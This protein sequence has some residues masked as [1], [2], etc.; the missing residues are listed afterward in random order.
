MKLSKIEICVIGLGY[1][2]LSV[3]I[4][5][6]KKYR[7]FGYD[8][9]Q[10]RI[11]ELKKF[12][13]INQEIP[14]KSLRD[15]LNKNLSL[16]ENP[17][18]IENKDIYIV[19]VPT[20]IF[21]NNKPDLSLVESAS[22]LVGKLLKKGSIVIYESTFYPGCT[23]DICIPIIEKHSKLKFNVDFFCGYSPERIN[24][25]DKAHTFNR[26]S[27]IVSGSDVK[28]TNKI[29][30]LYSS[31]VDKVFKSESIKTAEMAKII[32]NSQRDINIAFINEISI[33][34]SK[35]GIKTNE[36]LK[37][38]NTKWNFLD[39][40]PG[41]V[42]GH[43]IGVDPYY[44]AKKS[45]DIGYFPKVILSGRSINESM[46]YHYAS[47]ID[48]HIKK[49]DKKPKQKLLILGLTFKENCSDTRNSKVFDLIFHL[50][51]MN[52]SIECFDPL[53][54]SK[55]GL[56]FKKTTT[57]N[58]KLIN[59]RNYKYIILAVPHKKIL[60]DFNFFKDLNFK[61]KL[62]FDIKDIIHNNDMKN[63][64]KF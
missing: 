30:N 47:V 58:N 20:P 7:V 21:K 42:G 1:V 62:I 17:S 8:T 59:I 40:K 41:L 54:Q 16:V 51:N 35:I 23:E 57:F 39:F 3:A 13:D 18:E 44:L 12:N 48:K 27:K 10:N 45:R 52:Y 36:V 5:F 33:I 29:F 43:C 53:V 56:D 6:S 60:R 4:G 32:E 22:K 9:D 55:K 24:P 31:V 26:I 28:T 64:I 34:C 2:G 46:S 61:N 19:T 15:L 63:I 37:S 14:K 50:Q 49:I 11:L 25:G 38:A